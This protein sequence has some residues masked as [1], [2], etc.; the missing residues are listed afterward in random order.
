MYLFAYLLF[1]NIAIMAGTLCALIVQSKH[2]QIELANS[3]LDPRQRFAPASGTA[4]GERRNLP[5][6][7]KQR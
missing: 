2:R 7:G 5:V 3:R 1:T 6:G 4:P